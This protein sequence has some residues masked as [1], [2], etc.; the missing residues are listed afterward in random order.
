MEVCIVQVASVIKKDNLFIETLFIEKLSNEKKKDNQ[1]TAVKTLVLV[2]SI[3][4]IGEFLVKFCS[5]K[6][7]QTFCDFR[8]HLCFT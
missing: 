1:K 7:N 4:C 5:N 6:R 3:P 2:C 8:H